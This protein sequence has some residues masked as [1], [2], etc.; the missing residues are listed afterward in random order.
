M[1]Y[2]ED[3]YGKSNSELIM[4]LG[5]RFKEYR[6][7]CRMTQKEVSEKAGISLFTVKT[8]ESGRAYNITMGSF[9]AMLRAISYLEE[10]EK[11]LPELPP[12][13]EMIEFIN[14]NKPKRIRNG[15]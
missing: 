2:E 14:K 12:T 1:V 10:I 15:K 9:I 7:A 6:L 3:L 8:L 5:S 13:P 4:E 11:M